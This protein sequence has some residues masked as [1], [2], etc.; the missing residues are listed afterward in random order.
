[1]AT[2]RGVVRD[3]AGRGIISASVTLRGIG[4]AFV[5]GAVPDSLGAFLVQGIGPGAY[6]LR[7]RALGFQPV[8]RELVITVGTPTLQL[9]AIVLARI[10]VVLDEQ[11]VTSDADIATL[12]PERAVYWVKNLPLAGTGSAVDVLRVTPSVEVDGNDRLSLRGNPNVVIH[13]DGRPSPLRGEQLSQF[14]R[15]LHSATVDRIE[16]VTSPSA[17]ADPE[18]TA[19][20]INI[21]LKQQVE[22]PLSASIGLTV[23]S[24][25]MISPSASL[26]QQRGRLKWFLAP[27]ASFDER[28]NSGGLERRWDRMD[29]PAT[30][31]ALRTGVARTRSAGVTL[32]SEH[33]TTPEHVFSLDAAWST[34]SSP[35]TSDAAYIYADSGGLSLGRFRQSS[36]VSATN[37]MWDIAATYRNVRSKDLIPWVAELRTTQVGSR[38]DNELS[39]VV[40][41]HH[42]SVEDIPD[43]VRANASRYRQP[44]V[45]GQLDYTRVLGKI[46]KIEAGTK[47]TSRRTHAVSSDSLLSRGVASVSE[48]PLGGRAIL[49]EQLLAGYVVISQRSGKWSAQEGLRLERTATEL[50]TEE[51]QKMP[52]FSVNRHY[53]APFP[54]LIVNY[55]LSPQ[56]S[57][58]F[59]ATR[60]IARPWAQ[61]LA[62]VTTLLDQ[63]TLA[64]GNP[65]L[66]PE[67]TSSLELTFTDA[68]S[69][70]SIQVTP[71]REHTQNAV[72]YIR[73]IDSAGVAIQ[74]PENVSRV[75]SAGVDLSASLRLGRAQ[76][77]LGS[78]PQ[79][80]S[81]WSP[82]LGKPYAVRDWRWNI[83][84]NGL[85][86]IRSSTA[87]Q[88][89][90]LYRPGTRTEAGESQAFGW[91][92][93]GIRQT[94]A[95]GKG[96]VAVAISDPFLWQ[97][98]SVR[99]QND[100]LRDHYFGRSESRSITVSF[101]RT[102][103]RDV[104]VRQRAGRDDPTAAPPP[105][106]P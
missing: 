85:Y 46:A 95:D 6:D 26:A 14:L 99:F 4:G 106:I 16:V 73:V 21:V 41:Q 55:A 57:L 59:A 51:S 92:N 88:L 67:F 28:T 84:A 30:E 31:S 104:R 17:K 2:I 49:D 12:S 60:R 44:T 50:T 54:S 25:G 5:G 47:L 89:S 35:S 83:R 40:Y 29:G 97:R 24:T 33:A 20:I 79:W 52:A 23:G 100:D 15:Q 37:S 105:P 71:Y 94:L 34:G 22:L 80:Y 74:R 72:R 39:S 93:A 42:S 76:L 82:Q 63:R 7:V 81:S 36:R 98:Y 77:T 96:S 11:R 86:R 8:E 68:F 62:P 53:T 56:R 103:G 87:F 101:Q 48:A 70:G 1:M 58:R 91:L 18:G 38:Q 19:G 61:S 78:N 13:V 27:F 10:A 102:F 65:A 69:F 66:Q 45:I 43:G 75:T 90:G 3:S 64:T 9:G 32:R